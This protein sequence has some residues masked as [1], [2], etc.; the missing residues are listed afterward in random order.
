[1]TYPTPKQNSWKRT[2]SLLDRLYRLL[3]YAYPK[4]FRSAYGPRMAQLLRDRCR[5]TLQQ[6]GLLGLVP[7]CFALLYDL[8]IN[9]FL[10]R[11]PSMQKT[12]FYILPSL[13]ALGAGLLIGY[14]DLVSSQ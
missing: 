8:A 7:L 9:T 12:A 5:N 13:I 6:R 10:E 2:I 1:M 11:Y 3:L 4:A 14:G